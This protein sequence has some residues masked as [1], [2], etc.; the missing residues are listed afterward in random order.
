MNKKELSTL[1]QNWAQ[2]VKFK[3]AA[4]VSQAKGQRQAADAILKY[5]FDD[6]WNDNTTIIEIGPG[7]ALLA[8][9]LFDRHSISRYVLVDGP[10]QLDNAKKTL[11]NYLDRVEMYTPE[12]ISNI[13]DNFD[14]F[15]SCHCLPET[16]NEYQEF[17]FKTFLPRSKK[18]MIEQTISSNL[19]KYVPNVIALKHA[20]EDYFTSYKQWNCNDE[21]KNL[22]I[23]SH[24]NIYIAK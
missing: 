11:S 19:G 13:T 18:L 23:R 2:Q 6:K 4:D 21:F 7:N 10:R 1:W 20:L 14:L 3:D 5:C 9:T 8:K 22:C 16:P 24:Q 15:I 12:Q 17:I